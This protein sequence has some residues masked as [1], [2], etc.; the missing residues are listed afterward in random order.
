MFGD[1]RADYQ[2][3]K[4]GCRL[5]GTLRLPGRGRW[6]VYAQMRRDERA[7][8]SWVAVSAG[9]GTHSASD[10]SRYAYFPSQR[11][12]GL[13]KTA[14]GAVLYGAMLAL[15]YAT[16]VLIQSSRRARD[17]RRGQR[18]WGGQSGPAAAPGSTRRR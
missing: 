15:L 2:A 12:G 7:L 11:S 6:F 17:L 1:E 13:V 14:G 10:P 18:A 4:R 9:S 5:R 8:K 3:T 16:F